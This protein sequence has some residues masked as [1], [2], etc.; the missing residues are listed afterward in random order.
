MSLDPKTEELD[1]DPEK[2]YILAVVWGS[3]V[4][5]EVCPLNEGIPPNW[6]QCCSIEFKELF[7]EHNKRLINIH[8]SSNI[9]KI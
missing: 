6:C 1:F 3:Y 8:I 5:K 2:P 9:L 7:V 4:G